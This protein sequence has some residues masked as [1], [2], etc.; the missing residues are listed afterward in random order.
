MASAI[1]TTPA[2]GRSC[3]TAGYGLRHCEGYRVVGPHGSL[4]F[5]EDV[6]LDD[7]DDVCA[8]VVGGTPRVVVPSAAIKSIDAESELVRLVSP[9]GAAG[10]R[11]E[12]VLA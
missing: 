7:F 4:G 9:T 10:R 12:R 6:R 5:V 11:V 2:R 1:G 8:I 3:W